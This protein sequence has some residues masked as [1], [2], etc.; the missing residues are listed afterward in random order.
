LEE[1]EMRLR[2]YEELTNREPRPLDWKFDR[3]ALRAFLSKLEA[4]K[5]LLPAAV[6]S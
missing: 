5:A 1:V 4:K 6:A 3:A 2:L